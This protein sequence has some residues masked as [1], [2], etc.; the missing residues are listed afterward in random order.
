MDAKIL[1]LKGLGKAKVRCIIKNYMLLCFNESIEYNC[2][3]TFPLYQTIYN[4]GLPEVSDDDPFTI[5][6]LV[7]FLGG[8]I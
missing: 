5:G 6:E 1:I 2:E 3:F 8:K 4:N 7:E